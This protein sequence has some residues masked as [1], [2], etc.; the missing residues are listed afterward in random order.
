[1]CQT[2][3]EDTKNSFVRAL[4]RDVEKILSSKYTNRMSFIPDILV[5]LMKIMMDKNCLA[6]EGRYRR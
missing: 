1:M 2:L 4:V 6:L 5:K 3:G